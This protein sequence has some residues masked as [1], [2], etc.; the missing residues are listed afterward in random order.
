ML[1]CKVIGNIVSTIKHPVLEG[2]KIMIVR[3]VDEKGKFTGD[4]ITALDT[5]QAGPG[6]YVLLNDEGHSARLILG[7]KS[8]PVRSVIVGIIDSIT[9][10]KQE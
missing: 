6:D 5:V 7:D 10:E 9:L 3:P 8:A 4:S 2:H 1:L